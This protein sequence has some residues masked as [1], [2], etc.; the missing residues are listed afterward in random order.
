MNKNFDENMECL[1]IK[2]YNIINILYNFINHINRCLAMNIIDNDK[3]NYYLN[4]I[5]TFITN[6]NL[7][8]NKM[9]NK[10]NT[11]ETQIDLNN[12]SDPFYDI[13]QQVLNYATNIGIYSLE[14]G[15]KLLFN[16]KF[17]DKLSSPEKTKFKLYNKI[18]IPLQFVYEN[19]NNENGI[20]DITI[21][22][23][24]FYNDIL[25]TDC[26]KITIKCYN[27]KIIFI[28]SFVN[29]N[30]GIILKTSQICSNFIYLQKK[31]L[32][33][34][35]INTNKSIDN[36]FCNNYIKNIITSDILLYNNDT[37]YDK[38]TNDYKIYLK[39]SK[40]S[41]EQ[42]INELH[43]GNIKYIFKIILLLLLGS[44]DNITIAGLLFSLIKEKKIENCNIYK[45][46]YNNLNYNLQLKLKKVSVNL[47]KECEQ[48]KKISINNL[49]LNYLVIV[50]KGMPEYVKKIAI[51][52]IDGI[53]NN[54]NNSDYNKQ[55]LY[56][57][58]LLDFPWIKDEDNDIFIEAGSTVEK[59]V[60]F[61]DKIMDRINT[62]VYGHLE[63]KKN[64]CH[65]MG[66]WISNPSSSG[67]AIGL[68]GPAG[69]GKTLIAK[70]F[71]EAIGIP[72]VQISLSGHN[73]GDHLYGHNYTYNSSQPGIIIRKMIEAGSSRCIIYFDELDKTCTKNNTNEI[74]NI[75]INLID[76]N[77]NNEFQDRFFNELT[78]PLNKV[79]FIFSYNDSSLLDSI[80]LDRITEIKVD[81]FTVYDKIN[82]SKQYLINDICNDICFNQSKI[83]INNN[84]IEYIIEHYTNEA[85]VRELKRNL[86]KIY[87]KLNIDK[88]YRINE[89]DMNN[90]NKNN[91][92][93][94]KI[95]KNMID[96][97]LDKKIISLRKI[98]SEDIEG[99]VN[100]LYSASKSGNGGIMPIQILNNYTGNNNKFILKLTGYQG[101]IMKESVIYSFTTAMHLINDN[102]KNN[103]IKKNKLGLH[104]HTPNG[105]I[106]KDGSSAGCAFT[107]AFV[108]VILNKKVKHNIAITGE[109]ELNGKIMAVGGLI[110]KL[111]G[112]KKSGVKCVYLPKENENSIN[113]ILNE[114]KD[115]ID[116]TFNIKLVSHIIEILKD[117][118]ID[119]DISEFNINA[120]NKI[121]KYG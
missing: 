57:K 1:I 119:F 70:S 87:L 14:D 53:K 105:E 19:I 55:L 25:I 13:K 108:S 39:I 43:S 27:K 86:E 69:V 98:H 54:T 49:D 99:I 17:K 28:G 5:N 114:Y 66:K 52:K 30:I 8:Y 44:D 2:Y 83:D 35:L 80:L 101:T 73:D 42:L 92:K 100:G 50:C 40:M 32:I 110:Y 113:L 67:S 121:T 68:V 58:T 51:N 77:M 78:F 37:F 106:P 21:T 20:N 85:G 59:S 7:Q 31:K 96:E 61:I 97:Y 34:N 89:F 18:F 38:I 88:I 118:I 72:F 36:N 120:Y 6:I 117:V 4:K 9:A 71:G 112:A 115:L 107:T 111:Y 63:C 82:I 76:F 33:D 41:F 16:V 12:I 23:E 93:I 102:I 46:I 24:N 62:K 91:D 94:I 56:V 48:L 22:K 29:D 15:L 103:F 64:I 109:I 90:N 11:V 79:I 81:P 104:I 60:D 75:L 26:A 95:D 116:K 65:L 84:E 3:Q 10:L 45:I 74:Y 47:K